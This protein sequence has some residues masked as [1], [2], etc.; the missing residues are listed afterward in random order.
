M[1]RTAAEFVPPSPGN[2]ISSALFKPNHPFVE[3]LRVMED[4]A[5]PRLASLARLAQDISGEGDYGNLAELKSAL[6]LSIATKTPSLAPLFEDQTPK[7]YGFSANTLLAWVDAMEKGQGDNFLN[8]VSA[9]G[10]LKLKPDQTLA[11]TTSMAPLEL[12]LRQPLVPQISPTIQVD[13]NRLIAMQAVLE[14]TNIDLPGLVGQA[15]NLSDQ[16]NANLSNM[17][18]DFAR[19]IAAQTNSVLDQVRDGAIRSVRQFST[20]EENQDAVELRGANGQPL[21]R[22]MSHRLA[23]SQTTDTDNFPR[24][25]SLT[26]GGGSMNVV[27]SAINI[28]SGFKAAVASFGKGA[29]PEYNIEITDHG[30]HIHVEPGESGFAAAAGGASVTISA[31]SVSISIAPTT[32]SRG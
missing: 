30:A 5:P 24:G 20:R 15:I 19:S 32:I 26:T 29:A 16:I 7:D 13:Q 27:G 12:Q 23:T 17:A 18:S 8:K 21:S 31:P 6:E 22:R 10:E 3:N 9:T 2:A 4:N 1:K 25:A 28:D 14:A 11:R